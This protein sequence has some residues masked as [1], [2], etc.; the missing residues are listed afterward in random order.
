MTKENVKYA[1]V[2]VYG[3][4]III[5]LIFLFIKLRKKKELFKILKTNTMMHKIKCLNM[6]KLLKEYKM[7][8]RI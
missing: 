2:S 5:F 3:I 1:L 4:N 6:N 7:V 8:L